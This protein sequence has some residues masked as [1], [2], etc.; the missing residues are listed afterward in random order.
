MLGILSQRYPKI[1]NELKDEKASDRYL[2]AQVAAVRTNPQ[3]QQE[4]VILTIGKDSKVEEGIEFIVY[5]GSQYIVK[6]RADRVLDGTWS[7][8]RVI[9]ES[10]N[11]NNLQVPA[12]R[13]RHQPALNQQQQE[14]PMEEQDKIYLWLMVIAFAAVLLC[15]LFC[16]M[17]LVDLKSQDNVIRRRC[18]LGTTRH[19]GSPGARLRLATTPA[20]PP[21]SSAW[22]APCVTASAAYAR[23]PCRGPRGPRMTPGVRAALRQ[24]AKAAEPSTAQVVSGPPSM[25]PA[26]RLKPLGVCRTL[27]KP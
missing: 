7:S 16:A 3:G 22:W 18:P 26:S 9:P 10:W 14:P 20:S 17:E 5:R 8:C 21:G 25:P 13:L 12:G 19:D 24:A 4:I 23:D 2:L 11:T 1:W 15:T 6:V 27:M